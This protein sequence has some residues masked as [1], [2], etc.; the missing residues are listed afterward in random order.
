MAHG[1]V[2]LALLEGRFP[3]S[4][5]GLL[6][7][8][9]LRFFTRESIEE[10]LDEAELGLAEVQHQQLRLDASEVPFDPGAVPPGLVEALAKDP[11][12][13][14]YQFVIKAIPIES[15]GLREMQRRMRNLAE[16]VSRLRSENEQ[17]RPLQEALAAIS[18]REGQLRASLIETHEQL[19]QREEQLNRLREDIAPWLRRYERLKA[20]PLGRALITARRLRRVMGAVGR[21]GRRYR[22]TLRQ[23]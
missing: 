3:Y 22:D 21:R 5:R 2:R 8:T 13:T 7:E 1:S 23:L 20:T 18:S 14:T 10:L 6:D 17:L 9:H 4:K 16:E 15:P 11:D 19:L 12:A